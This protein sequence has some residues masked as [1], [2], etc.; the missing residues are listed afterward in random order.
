[1]LS[2]NNQSKSINP[3]LL[4][5]Y[6]MKSRFLWDIQI[7]SWLSRKK[8]KQLSNRYAGQKAVI[9]CNGP[10]LLQTNFSLL[11]GVFTFG[12]N[13]INLLFDKSD[14]RP[15]CIVAINDF[16]LEQNSDF[17]NTTD[18]QLFIKYKA[19]SF[20]KSRPNTIFLH[21]CTQYKF[22]QDCSMSMNLGPT[23]TFTAMELAFYMGFSEVALI[24]CDHNFTSK[25]ISNQIVTAERKD[26]NHFDPN[27][28]ADGVKWQ[29]PDLA[30][31]ESY[32]T[33]AYEAFVQQGRKL[34]NATEGGNLEI[35]PRV[36]LQEFLK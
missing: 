7:E 23:V 34:F 8:L 3:Y 10:S 18:I 15:S 11:D 28:F 17:Y 12:L 36:S 35:Y 25:G 31:S 26:Q 33:L 4:G 32:Y 6:Q 16:V 2:T 5:L 21:S 1:M 20:I 19:A 14:F 24:G 13:K 9:I 27:Y 29:L 30:A 22:A